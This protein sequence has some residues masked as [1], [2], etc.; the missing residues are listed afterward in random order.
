MRFG[1]APAW[2]RAFAAVAL[3]AAVT[4]VFADLQGRVLAVA[5]AVA[6]AALAV[7]DRRSSP[8]L[9]V[10]P[11]GLTVREVTGQRRLAWDVVETVA[12]DERIR[13][14]RI[15]HT[16][17]VDAGDVLVVLGRRSLDAD[18]VTAARRIVAAAPADRR[19]D[20]GGDIRRRA[21]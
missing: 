4:A 20:L 21:R 12:V 8:R 18:P 19:A 6:F 7:V 3:V 11:D 14:G 1:P 10:D 2:A 9:V 5:V 16:L 13:F 17:E 15:V